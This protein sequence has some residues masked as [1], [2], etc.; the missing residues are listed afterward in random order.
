MLGANY[1]FMKAMPLGTGWDFERSAA[2]QRQPVQRRGGFAREGAPA[3]LARSEAARPMARCLR[4][5]HQPLT[6]KALCRTAKM[7][8][9]HPPAPASALPSKA[10]AGCSRSG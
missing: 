3:A 5:M 2:A 4:Q 9:P 10:L 1:F 7:P 6:V 8:P